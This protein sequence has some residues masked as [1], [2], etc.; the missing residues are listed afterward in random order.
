M[1]RQRVP[2]R[3]LLPRPA[4]PLTPVA[5]VPDLDR[6]IELSHRL[7]TVNKLRPRR[8]TTGDAVSSINYWVYGRA[9]K[10]CLRCGTRIQRSELGEEELRERAIEDRSIYVCPYCQP[11]WIPA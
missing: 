9:K 3:N 11:A 2:Q 7:L 4:Q 8:A 6:I 1:R 5:E 10:T